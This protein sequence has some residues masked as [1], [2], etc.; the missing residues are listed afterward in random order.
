[1]NDLYEQGI[2]LT[3]VSHHI[4]TSSFGDRG[5]LQEQLV[6]FVNELRTKG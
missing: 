5:V 3:L 2:E 6:A 1:M 4:N